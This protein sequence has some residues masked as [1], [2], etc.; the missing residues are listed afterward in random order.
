ML[1][2]TVLFVGRSRKN[3]LAITQIMAARYPSVHAEY[4]DNGAK[5]LQIQSVLRPE[6]VLIDMELRDMTTEHLIC[7]LKRDIVNPFV[8][9][10]AGCMKEQERRRIIRMGANEV[11]ETPKD[12]VKLEELIE[13]QLIRR[14][15]K[16]GNRLNGA[17]LQRIFAE[18]GVSF[19]LKGYKYLEYALMLLLAEEAELEP[20]GAL[21]ERIGERFGC[22]GQSVERNIRYAIKLCEGQSEGWGDM[23]NKEFISRLIAQREKCTSTLCSP[24]VSVFC[25]G[26]RVFK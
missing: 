19:N 26:Y 1:S 11:V 22:M 7:E 23:G 24:R 18:A 16:G 9:V 8:V 2:G 21:Y 14:M 15:K 17:S 13:R 6:V 12:G 25:S 10:C 20:I 3:A 4:A 5:A